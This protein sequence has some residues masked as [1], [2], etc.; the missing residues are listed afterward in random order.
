MAQSCIFGYSVTALSAIQ[1]PKMQR[2]CYSLAMEG[3]LPRI[4]EEKIAKALAQFP[5]VMIEGPRGAGKTTTASLFAKSIVRLPQDLGSLRSDPEGFLALLQPPILIDEWQLAGTDFLWTLKNLV[6][7]D[8]TAGRFIL[9]GSV[10]PASYGPTY[11][12]TGRSVRVTIFPMTA[13]EIAG[14]GNGAQFLSHFLDAS[15]T[16]TAGETRTF[17]VTKLFTTGFPAARALPDAAM[18]L[19]S[20]AATVSQRAGDEGRDSTRFYRTAQVLATLEAQAVPDQRIWEAAD[21]NKATWKK[22]QD[23]LARTW[24]AAPLPAFSSNRLAR[25]TEYPKRFMIDAALSLALAQVNEDELRCN[26]MLLGRYLE[27]YVAAQLRPQADA[28]KVGLYHLRTSG[29]AHEVD[30]IVDTPKGVLAFEVKAATR[31]TAS[32]AK[33][34][35]WLRENLGERFLKGAVLYTGADARPLTGNIWAI[36]I[37]LL[38]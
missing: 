8:S 35:D 17:D 23:L 3:Y 16:V 5:I 32:D 12:L 26:P 29:G 27:S 21:I 28:L 18:F 2:I 4:A 30:F 10:E 13:S 14:S 11:P 31:A 19:E 9:T 20:Y 36:P 37:S 38:G 1:Q 7:A 34:L 22:Y 6:D 33:H 24:L 15:P 25:I